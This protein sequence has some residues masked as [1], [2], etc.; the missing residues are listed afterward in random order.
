LTLHKLFVF[1]VVSIPLPKLTLDKLFLSLK[2]S[3]EWQGE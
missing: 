1:V 3:G 2:G